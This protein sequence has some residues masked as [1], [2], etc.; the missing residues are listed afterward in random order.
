MKVIL[1]KKKK[2]PQHYN[3]AMLYF[4]KQFLHPRQFERIFPK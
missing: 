3:T 2:N 4:E 1:S